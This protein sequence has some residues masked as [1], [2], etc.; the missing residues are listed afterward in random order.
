MTRIVK[1]KSAAKNERSTG[2]MRN[3]LNQ[4][5]DRKI[6]YIF[7]LEQKFM[8]E[9]YEFHQ[10]SYNQFLHKRLNATLE[11]NKRYFEN[12]VQIRN[13]Y[14]ELLEAKIAARKNKGKKPSK[15]VDLLNHK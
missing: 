11:E 13:L 15:D 6:K 1:L 14:N 4:E 3:K 2:R 9:K 5:L 10:S 12:Y 8:N 7:E